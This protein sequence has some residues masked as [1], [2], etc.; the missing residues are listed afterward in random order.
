M[1]NFKG[2]GLLVA[3]LIL[4]GVIS[5]YLSSPSYAATPQQNCTS[6]PGA[7][8]NY[9]THILYYAGNA[10]CDSQIAKI[11]DTFQVQLLRNLTWTTVQTQANQCTNCAR[12]YSPSQF[13][14]YSYSAVKGER[15]R[16]IEC[17]SYTFYD[18][19]GD[20]G[21]QILGPWSM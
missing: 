11:R 8:P 12:L 17:A 4:V 13:G 15:L 3:L 6:T 2:L 7:H 5:F 16:L 9:S 21:C 10:G 18:G 14:T 19:S 20:G 1:R